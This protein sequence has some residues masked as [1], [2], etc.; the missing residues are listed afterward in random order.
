MLTLLA[1]SMALAQEPTDSPASPQPT[2]LPTDEVPVDSAEAPTG[3][4]AAP[5][6]VGPTAARRC[7]DAAEGTEIEVC[8][9]LVSESP[10][11]VDAIATALVA[12]IDQASSGDRDLLGALLLLVSDETGVQ[13]AKRLGELADPRAL[14]PLTHAGETRESEV[15]IAAAK[16]LTAY[17]EAIEPLSRWVVDR[18][19]DVEVRRAAAEALGELGSD[20]AAD[21]LLVTLRSRRV[22]SPLRSTVMD[23]VASKYPTRTDELGGQVTRDGSAW[24]AGGGAFGLGYAMSMAGAFGQAELAGFGAVTG[25]VAGGTLGWVAGRAWPMEAADAS[26]ITTTGMMATSGGVVVGAAF[27]DSTPWWTGLGAGA[28]GYGSAISFRRFHRGTVLDSLEASSLS[29]VTGLAAGSTAALLSRRN[30]WNW[31]GPTRQVNAPILAAGIGMLGGLAV[32]HA[33]APSVDISRVD[34]P[35]MGLASGYGLAAGLLYP[36]RRRGTYPWLGLA[37]GSLAGY[38]IA[39]VLDVPSDV[40]L[41]AGAGAAYGGVVGAG[42]GMLAAP[43]DTT[44]FQRDD[45]LISAVALAG[46]TAGLGVGTYLAATNDDVVDKGDVLFTGLVTGWAAWQSSGWFS[47][48][49][50]RLG[51]KNVDGVFVL[52]PA[53]AGGVAAALSP[54]YDVPISYSFTGVSMGLWGG[55]LGGTIAELSDANALH[56]NA[57]LQ[58]ALIGS[59]VGIGAGIVLALP[60]LQASPLVIGLANAGGVLGGSVFALGT[61][62]VG[63][64]PDL[65]LSVS[66]IGAGLGFTGGAIVGAVVH[67]KGGTREIA[68]LQ[69]PGIHLPGRWSFSPSAFP[70]TENTLHYGATLSVTEW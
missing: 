12:H 18:D 32:G 21:A 48:S 16:A 69:L 27:G 45:R 53:V 35:F 11:E 24:L 10:D 40:V 7:A 13:G 61:A 1:L 39:G 33:I 19:L 68:G 30:D 14:G 26:F 60:P 46:T 66:L 31:D 47:V 59:N 54:Y 55:Y 65:I 50:P 20:A 42:I 15:A 57:V 9:Q 3:E 70:D 23:V 64:E 38:G 29:A 25:G 6:P 51:T 49:R 17:P 44:T 41:G 43:M 52:A 2:D 5:A 28:V 67:R 36:G 8:L 37:A 22:P 4:T 56:P 58:Y 34:A 63:N 62:F